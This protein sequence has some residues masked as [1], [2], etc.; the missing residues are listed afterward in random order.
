MRYHI[1]V[2]RPI[3]ALF[4]ATLAFAGAS[5][6][7][8][9]VNAPL[10]RVD[11][12]A[13]YRFENFPATPDNSDEL[14]VILALSGGGSRATAFSYGILEEL[15]R[16]PIHLHGQQKS[17]LDEV[18]VITS[19]SGSSFVAAYYALHGEK[20]FTDFPDKYLHHDVETDVYAVAFNPLNW[21][22]LASPTFDRID[23]AAEVYDREIFQ[24]HTF[25][26]LLQNP[27]RPYLIMSATDISLGSRFDFTQEQF[28]FLNS[29]L[30]S[31]P[32]ARAVAASSA[33]PVI[34]SP[35]AI[36]N[37]P[38]PPDFT[39]PAWIA[40]TLAAPDPSP[41]LLRRARDLHSYADTVNRP[42]IRLLDGA[43]AD[44]MGLRSPLTALVSDAPDFSLRRLINQHRIKNL[45]IISACA[46]R[47]PPIVWDKGTSAPA[48]YDMLYFTASTP[49]RNN[50]FDTVTVFR[51]FLEADQLAISNQRLYLDALQ[52]SDPAAEKIQHLPEYN[53]HF[54]AI[55][56][57]TIPDP[58][59]RQRAESIETGLSLKRK[60]ADDLRAAASS[61][62]RASPDFQRL[63]RQLQ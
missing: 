54:I 42:H 20:T 30:A 22:R 31:V 55:D 46:I 52:R 53:S 41:R 25:A 34:L 40:S 12:H 29:D 50:A 21:L 3:P 44:Y 16:T 15:A 26:D 1:R 8:Y 18:D 56:F 62:L 19:V 39:E 11:P 9:P 7:H 17:L 61:A 48:W 51:D 37:H 36:E 14:F 38:R 27:R 28:D 35:L 24:G 59:L 33:Y 60:D 63:L 5:C 47:T 45:V 43:I 6:A 32:I 23:L 57:S 49:I 2:Q 13:G 10:A 4:L 58:A